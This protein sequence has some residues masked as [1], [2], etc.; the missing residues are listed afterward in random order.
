MVEPPTEGSERILTT[1]YEN[2]CATILKVPSKDQV[3]LLDEFKARVDA[4]FACLGKFNVGKV[5]ENRQRLLEFCT[6]FD[7]SV[8]NSFFHTKPQHKVS[9]G[10]PRSK[11]WC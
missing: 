1:F 4:W 5:N 3:I 7:L 9:W 2:L 11:H 8:A 10:H 6:R